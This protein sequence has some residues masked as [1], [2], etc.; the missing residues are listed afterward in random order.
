MT[1]ELLPVPD[2]EWL[3]AIQHNNPLAF[4]EA[5]LDRLRALAPTHPLA[6]RLLAARD[7]AK[8][9]N[10]GN[11]PTNIG[12]EYFQPGDL[13]QA[14]RLHAQ[15][16]WPNT[17]PPGPRRYRSPL[18]ALQAG[19]KGVAFYETV[20]HAVFARAVHTLGL[21]QTGHAQTL[22]ETRFLTR[23]DGT[24]YYDHTH[25]K[26]LGAAIKALAETLIAALQEAERG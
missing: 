18:L 19:L 20:P 13:L 2:D 11:L 10:L 9:D 8:Y 24:P 16:R 25:P 14:Y 5:T 1:H 15:G 22:K 6:G 17:A 7:K 12:G 23:A 26:S 3:Y 4:T 21:Y